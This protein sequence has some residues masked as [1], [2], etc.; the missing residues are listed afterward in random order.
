MSNWQQRFKVHP[1][2]DLFPMMEAEEL[3]K[4]GADIKKNGL[5][6]QVKFYQDGDKKV[7]IIDGRNRLEAME[8]VGINPGPGCLAEIKTGNGFNPVAYIISLNIR[9]R[10]LTKRQQADLIVAALKAGEKVSRQLGGKPKKGGRPKSK[11]KADAVAAGKK[12]ASANARWNARS[13]RMRARP[14][15]TDLSGQ[16]PIRRSWTPLVSAT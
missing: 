12:R 4:L 11:L 6:E 7:V 9:R 3:A 16:S 14:R 8:R 5:R 15:P 13:P 2:T 1:A 10:H